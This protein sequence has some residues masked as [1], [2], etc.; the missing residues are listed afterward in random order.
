MRRLEGEPVAGIVCDPASL[1]V[2][3]RKKKPKTDR[4]DARK[5]VRAL[6]AWEVRGRWRSGRTIPGSGSDGR[7]RGCQA[8]AASSGASCS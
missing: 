6:K 7:G 5:R 3:R 8:V 4:M 1:E 2:V